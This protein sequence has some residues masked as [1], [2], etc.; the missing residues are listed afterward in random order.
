MCKRDF[1]YIAIALKVSYTETLAPSFNIGQVS[2]NIPAES[3]ESAWMIDYPLGMQPSESSIT[4]PSLVMLL[5]LGPNGFPAST[6]TEPKPRPG[7]QLAV[8]YLPS[9]EQRSR[10]FWIIVGFSLILGVGLLDFLTGDE[11]AF[12]LFYL[13]PIALLTWPV[14]RCSQSTFLF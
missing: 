1:V 12:S 11:V 9:L 3:S 8:N 4:I 14:D 5:A 6:R 2:A 10:L 13:I 7:Q